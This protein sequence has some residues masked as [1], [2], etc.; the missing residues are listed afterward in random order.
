ML[1]KA[2]PQ[3]SEECYWVFNKCRKQHQSGYQINR[4]KINHA[5]IHN[6]HVWFFPCF[7][8]RHLLSAGLGQSLNRPPAWHFYASVKS[9]LLTERNLGFS[10]AVLAH[11]KKNCKNVAAFIITTNKQTEYTARKSDTSFLI[12]QRYFVILLWML[13][14]NSIYNF[15]FRSWMTLE[16]PTRKN[17]TKKLTNGRTPSCQKNRVSGNE[18]RVIRPTT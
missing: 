5:C 4:D 12:L 8:W 18:N 14:S 16:G 10:I 3:E 17:L 11:W 1:N 15:N 13:P 2:K 9:W 7:Y 6:K